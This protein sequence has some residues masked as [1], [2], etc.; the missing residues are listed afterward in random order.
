MNESSSLQFT[1]CDSRVFILNL[2]YKKPI[3]EIEKNREI[4]WRY[5]EK[6][7]GNGTFLLSGRNLTMTGGF[8]IA[9]GVSRQEIENIIQEDP[10]LY[11]GL[12][13]YEVNEFTATKSQPGLENYIK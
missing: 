2:K 7:Y 13:E 3:K 9:K 11:N 10:F 8:I 6:Y 12:V 4:H 1:K 5:L